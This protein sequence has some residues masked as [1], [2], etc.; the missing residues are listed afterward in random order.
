M[1]TIAFKGANPFDYMAEWFK[2]ETYLKL[3]NFLSIQWEEGNFGQ[4]VKKVQ[5][6]HL[7]WERCL[8]DLQGKDGGSEFKN[9][10][11]TKLFNEGRVMKCRIC[12]VEDHN[13]LWCP[14]T[15]NIVS[16]LLQIVFM[17]VFFLHYHADECR[18]VVHI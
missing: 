11:R 10:S 18:D 17:W 15:I 6:W 2:K 16:F 8:V 13:R 9:R 12:H 14:Q 1:A 5:C 7:Q 4:Q 3:I